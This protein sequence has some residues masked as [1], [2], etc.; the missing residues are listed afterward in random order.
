MDIEERVA[1]IERQNRNLKKGIILAV[2]FIGGLFGMGQMSPAPSVIK[3]KEFQVIG[4]KGQ[5]LASMSADSE[6]DGFVET[7][8]A[9]EMRSSKILRLAIFRV[10]RTSD[11]CQMK[12]TASS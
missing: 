7:R 3:A 4:D 11:I 12:N 5:V 9:E 6:G 8:N 1:R 2:V 10:L